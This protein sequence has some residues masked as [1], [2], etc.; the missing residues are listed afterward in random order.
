VKTLGGFASLKEIVDAGL[1]IP[2]GPE[3]FC[4]GLLKAVDVPQLKRLAGEK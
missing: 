4:F 3:L 1:A 2:D